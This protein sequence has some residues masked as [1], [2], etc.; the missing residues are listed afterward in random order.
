MLRDTGQCLRPIGHH[1]YRTDQN[2]RESRCAKRLVQDFSDGETAV[3]KGHFSALYVYAANCH[4]GNDV[5]LSGMRNSGSA[6]DP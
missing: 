4:S 6:I 1:S 3:I 2:E 5:L